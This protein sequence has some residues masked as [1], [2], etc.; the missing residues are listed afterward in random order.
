MTLGL[1]NKENQPTQGTMK[2]PPKPAVINSTTGGEAKAT[3]EVGQ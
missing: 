2:K 3:Q 1:I